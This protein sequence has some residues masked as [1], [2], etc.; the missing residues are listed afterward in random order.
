MLNLNIKYRRIGAFLMDMMLIKGISDLVF[1][2]LYFIVGITF[3]IQTLSGY[4]MVCLTMSIVGLMYGL[5]CRKV[6]KGTLGKR[7]LRIEI[8]TLSGQNL[9]T[10]EYISREW[11]KWIIIYFFT[12]FALVINILMYFTN[13]SS[14]HDKLSKTQVV[15]F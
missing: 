1:V 8:V 10:A 6:F 14:I 4:F 2:F 3:D 13:N 11:A 7:L 9:S 5:I 12:I 15:E